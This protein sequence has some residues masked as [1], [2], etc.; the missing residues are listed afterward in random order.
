MIIHSQLKGKEYCLENLP[1]MRDA[2]FNPASGGLVCAGGII[3]GV[4]PSSPSS[5]SSASSASSPA[6]APDHAS[7]RAVPD[8]NTARPAT[9]KALVGLLRQIRLANR[10]ANLDPDL[11]ELANVRA[12]QINGCVACL[13]VHAEEARRAGVAQWKLDVLAGWRG[14]HD[15][16]PAERAV[17]ELTEV[18]T[19]PGRHGGVGV[20]AEGKTP[21]MTAIAAAQEHFSAE[22]IAALEWSIVTINAFNRVSIASDHPV[23][24]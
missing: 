7:D 15:F 11:T 2:H 19:E 5:P 8:L 22:Q 23:A 13:S 21:V 6:S 4:P 24:R 9:Y 17:L 1:P 20:K 14:A 18:L 12:S 10:E 3:R 16:S